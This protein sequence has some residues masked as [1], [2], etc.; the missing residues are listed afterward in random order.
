MGYFI[1]VSAI[2]WGAVIIGCS[3]ALKGS[4]CYSAIQNILVA[5]ASIH[6]VLIGDPLVKQ[7]RK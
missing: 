2:I 5:G 1:I 7:S 4:E 6:I 3:M